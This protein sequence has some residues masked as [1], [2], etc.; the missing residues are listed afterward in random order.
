MRNKYASIAFAATLLALSQFPVSAYAVAIQENTVQE[1]AIAHIAPLEDPE[2]V[3]KRIHF[4]PREKRA[5]KHIH[6]DD[7]E[8]VAE[9]IHFN[10]LEKRKGGGGGGKGGGGGGGGKSSG[11]SSSGSSSGG[12]SSSSSSR[13][14]SY[15]YKTYGGRYGG[16]SATPYRAGGVSPLG[17]VPFLL[18]L[19][20]LALIWPGIWLWGVY[21]YHYNTLYNYYNQTL[22][23]NQSVPVQ[24]FCVQYNECACDD[25]GDISYLSEII[26]LNQANTST[27]ATV[28]GVW[29]L[30]INGTVANG[31]GE[32]DAG[33]TIGAA[34]SLNVLGY[35]WMVVVA[36]FLAYMM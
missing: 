28:D 34:S 6:A 35:T 24:C 20:A 12:K 16:G 31:T 17:L 21:S 33:D 2:E 7:A 8:Q 3:A 29:T 32:A 14:S 15:G 19:A 22:N 30:L 1:R 18:P 13:S 10:P 9:R 23:A 36:C 25:N 5:V 11:G 4:G 26:A 27:F